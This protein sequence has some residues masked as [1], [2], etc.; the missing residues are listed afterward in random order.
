[1]RRLIDAKAVPYHGACENTFLPITAAA[2]SGDPSA[3]KLLLAEEGVTCDAR[4][5]R[6]G[7]NVTPLMIA[8]QC[9]HADAVRCLLAHG[10]SASDSITTLP[11]TLVIRFLL[12]FGSS[13]F[14]YRGW[15][16][17]NT[18]RTTAVFV[19]LP[20]IFASI[21]LYFCLMIDLSASNTLDCAEA[22]GD[23][24]T[25]ELVRDAYWLG[26]S[27]LLANQEDKR[28][29]LLYATLFWLISALVYIMAMDV[30]PG[31]AS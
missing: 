25:I 10:A 16:W 21:F 2:A 4:V 30:I 7:L 1:M 6:E 29:F 3:I 17:C 15:V 27:G 13:Y 19:S 12:Y 31:L 24:E 11:S 20:L 9:G 26:H 18:L 22:S 28:N 14:L 23:E 5:G 8:A